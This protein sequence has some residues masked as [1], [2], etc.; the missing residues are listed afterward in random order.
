MKQCPELILAWRYSLR[1]L[2]Y[3]EPFATKQE[4]GGEKRF[5][6]GIDMILIIYGMGMLSIK[7]E[8]FINAWFLGKTKYVRV[9]FGR[10]PNKALYFWSH[11]MYNPL[12]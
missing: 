7:F 9:K 8:P 6:F 10:Y 2:P 3:I 1:L 4:I 12:K 5:Y 11:E